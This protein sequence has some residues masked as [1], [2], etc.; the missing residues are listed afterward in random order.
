MHRGDYFYEVE[1]HS[2]STHSY[3]H[4]AADHVRVTYQTA[5]NANGEGLNVFCTLS[6]VNSTSRPAIVKGNYTT[7]DGASSQAGTFC[8]G[9]DLG[10]RTTA[11]TGIHLYF[12]SGNIIMNDFAIYGLVK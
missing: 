3:D 7:V 2:S 4:D 1:V 5:G 6:Q 9:Q 10:I 8:G 12:G 11:I